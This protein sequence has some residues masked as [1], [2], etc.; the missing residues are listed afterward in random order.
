LTAAR[1]FPPLR[2]SF[3]ILRRYMYTYCS[4]HSG[5]RGGCLLRLISYI[6]VCKM[7]RV[8]KLFFCEENTEN[9]PQP[10]RVGKL[11]EKKHSLTLTSP[12]V[13]GA[14]EHMEG[15]SRRP[16]RSLLYP[17]VTRSQP[18]SRWWRRRRE[19]EGGRETLSYVAVR[20]KEERKS[21]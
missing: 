1:F 18:P 13:S 21:S 6:F 20:E 17:V 5:E 15:Q 16:R 7:N 11:G 19:K 4:L 10:P 9:T 2:L 12:E 14:L 8:R 3:T